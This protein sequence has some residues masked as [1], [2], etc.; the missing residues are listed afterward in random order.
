[1]EDSDLK[2]LINGIKALWEHP[3][4]Q[5]VDKII[6]FVIEIVRAIGSITAKVSAAVCSQVATVPLE[7]AWL[8]VKII[9]TVEHLDSLKTLLSHSQSRWT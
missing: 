4:F 9:G 3:C 7:V 1:L 5:S 8:V 6:L 2:I